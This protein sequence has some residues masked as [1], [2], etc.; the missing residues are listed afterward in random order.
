MISYPSKKEYIVRNGNSVIYGPEIRFFPN[1]TSRLYYLHRIW[2]T[3]K[4]RSVPR[5]YSMTMDSVTS[6]TLPS[7]KPRPQAGSDCVDWCGTMLQS[8]IGSAKA[9]DTRNKR[10]SRLL[11]KVNSG[12]DASMGAFF[13]EM[14][15]SVDMIAF[16]AKQLGSG[17]KALKKGN[18]AAALKI[19]SE[20]TPKKVRNI[21]V[22]GRFYPEIWADM[23]K[24]Q[25]RPRANPKKRNK[26]FP[27]LL[28]ELDYGWLP[29]VR[30]IFDFAAVLNGDACP[31]FEIKASARCTIATKS[32]SANSYS[33]FDDESLSVYTAR[34]GGRVYVTN[35]WLH[36]AAK[37]GVVNP[38]A[39]AWELVPFSFFVDQFFNI[40]QFLNAKTDFLGLAFSDYYETDHW[41]FTGKRVI[42]GSG[43]G[44]GSYSYKAIRVNRV[45]RPTPS[46][47]QVTWR[48]NPYAENPR[49]P[50]SLQQII[51]KAADHLAVCATLLSS[52]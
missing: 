45:L 1:H 5:P 24:Y 20:T 38:V 46:L 32:F 44:T 10:Y 27:D 14:K 7:I 33:S 25:P 4:S 51:R 23:P 6:Y 48:G 9:Q 18:P 37:M 28:L 47:P 8:A 11:D 31:P 34:C 40:G 2:Q 36:L 41:N 30:D 49:N 26:S 13:G 15:D 16:R 12:D 29:L 21:T 42:W 43:I 22:N 17:L 19:W 39:V 52:K 35:P 3:G 50:D